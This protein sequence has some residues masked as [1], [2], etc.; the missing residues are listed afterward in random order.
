MTDKHRR[1]AHSTAMSSGAGFSVGWLAG[2]IILGL[3][4]AAYATGYHNG[5]HHP[6]S[7]Q[8]PPRPS[9]CHR[10]RPEQAPADT[11]PRRARSWPR[12]P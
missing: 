6:R 8:P 12:P 11:P 9:L 10:R 1:Y 5:Q 2:G 7:A 3:L 4:V